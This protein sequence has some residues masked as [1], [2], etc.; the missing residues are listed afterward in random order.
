[1]TVIINGCVREIEG[2]RNLSL[3]DDNDCNGDDDDF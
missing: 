2:K 3:G 1:M